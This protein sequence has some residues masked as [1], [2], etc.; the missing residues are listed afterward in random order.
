MQKKWKESYWM[1][2]MPPY[3]T[4]SLDFFIAIKSDIFSNSNFIV[5]KMV[6]L[7]VDHLYTVYEQESQGVLK[8]RNVL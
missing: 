4:V 7:H 3:R 2:K 1:L 8:H 6:E 5:R